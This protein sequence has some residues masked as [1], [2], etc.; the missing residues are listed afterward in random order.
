MLWSVTR[1]ISCALQ[2]LLGHDYTQDEKFGSLSGILSNSNFTKDLSKVL[3]I[4]LTAHMIAVNNQKESVSLLP[5]SAKK[6]KVKSQTMTPT[7]PKSQGPET[8]EA[9]SKKRK[10]PKSKK[11]PSET[12]ETPP[13]PTEGYEQSHSVSSSNVPDPQDPERNI[14][15]RGTGL[16][17]TSLDE[18]TRKSQPLSKG[19][20]TDPKDSGG[21]K[22]PTD[23]GLPS[24]VP[25]E[26]LSKT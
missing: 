5:F 22:Q 10:Q 9:L 25:D 15:L 20:T 13:T 4:E 16:P 1:F 3:D 18:G 21:N 26:G 24:T 2:E 12:N 23:T 6:K 7:L 19:T 17:S 14:Q 11:T 8:S